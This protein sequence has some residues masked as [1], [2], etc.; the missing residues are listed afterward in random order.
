MLE[1]R[2]FQLASLFCLRC[3]A[4]SLLASSVARSS[5][6][7]RHSR[8]AVASCAA[9]VSNGSSI[10]IAWCSFIGFTS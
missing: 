4:L 5:F 1:G 3:L 7:A 6:F 8:S 2:S 9:A 10:R